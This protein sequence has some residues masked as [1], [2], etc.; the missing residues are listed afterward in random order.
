MDI[1]EGMEGAEFKEVLQ[2]ASEHSV[3]EVF[4]VLLQHS[5]VTVG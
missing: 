3:D 2:G 1:R 5:R 4:P